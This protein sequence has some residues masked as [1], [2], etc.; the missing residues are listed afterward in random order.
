MIKTLPNKRYL[1]ECFILNKDGLLVWRDR[2][3]H[4]FGIASKQSKFNKTWAGKMAGC[5]MGA[6]YYAVSVDSKRYK[7][8]RLIYQMVHG[9]ADEYSH[10]DHINGNPSDNRI[11]NLRGATAS[12]NAV[13]FKG[14]R[15]DSLSKVR[16]VSWNRRNKKWE[17][18]ANYLGQRFYLG[19]YSDLKEAAKVA[20]DKRLELFGD[21]WAGQNGY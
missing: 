15:I 16:G 2:P 17:A 19:L 7:A 10:I 3:I 6:G 8:H 20:Y 12:S 14:S 4:H 9:D 18:S 5:D 13:N 1:N 11:E 21:S